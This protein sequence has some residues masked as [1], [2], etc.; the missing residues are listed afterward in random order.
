MN[1]WGCLI[2]THTQALLLMDESYTNSLGWG[3]ALLK[4]PL[5]PTL[6]PCSEKDK[7]PCPLPQRTPARYQQRPKARGLC[8][9]ANNHPLAHVP[10]DVW[11]GGKEPSCVLRPVHVPHTRAG[12]CSGEQA[13]PPPVVLAT[14]K[15][16]SLCP[17][18]STFVPAPYW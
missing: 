15:V 7:W 1:V 8:F 11:L 9:Q 17:T 4:Q 5:P 13:D 16:I 18:Y 10:C 3:Q 14:N 12:W 2:L 6:S